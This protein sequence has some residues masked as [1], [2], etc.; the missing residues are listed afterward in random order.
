M[1]DNQKCVRRFICEVA[2]GILPANDYATIIKDL[3]TANLDVIVDSTKEPYS[4]A[5]KRGA[6]HKTIEKCQADYVCDSTG[7]EIYNNL[8]LIGA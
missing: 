4:R 5:A 6:T 2:T 3:L 1:E 7:Q 8:N